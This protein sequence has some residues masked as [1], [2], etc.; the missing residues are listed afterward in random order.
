MVVRSGADVMSR[1]IGLASRVA[2]A[3][4]LLWT[5]PEP[6]HA[7]HVLGRGLLSCPSV[8][9]FAG[10]HS[11]LGQGAT[12]SKLPPYSRAVSPS[13][14]ADS[15]AT[16]CADCSVGG[17]KDQTKHPGKSRCPHVS[18]SIHPIPPPGIWT[19]PLWAG[20]TRPEGPAAKSPPYVVTVLLTDLHPHAVGIT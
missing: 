15:M 13:L 2:P 18:T 8:S 19:C 4:I 12:G 16:C 10:K 14:A 7:L 5:P 3:I 17:F 9:L 20:W 11:Q 6:S 1:W